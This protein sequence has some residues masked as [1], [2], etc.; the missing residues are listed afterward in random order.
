MEIKFEHAVTVLLSIQV[1]LL[2]MIHSV[3]SDYLTEEDDEDYYKDSCSCY[4]DYPYYWYGYDDVY[5]AEGEPVRDSD[6]NE[7]NSTADN[8]TEEE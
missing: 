7:D 2:L 6:A 8:S 4:C 5:I 1:I 3:V